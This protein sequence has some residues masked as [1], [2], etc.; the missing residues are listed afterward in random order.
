MKRILLICLCP[1][2][3]LSSCSVPFSKENRR[4]EVILEE[5]LMQFSICDGFLYQKTGDAEHPLTDAMLTRLFEGADLADLRYVAS[6]AVF[7]S[8]RYRSTEIMIIELYDISHR[9]ALQKLLEKR[10]K[11][12]ENAVVLTNG[13]YLYLICTEQ[14]EEIKKFLLSR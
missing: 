6:M 7:L 13:V 8:R 4:A 12:K 3:F 14:N 5:M 1:I 2:I 10:A 9:D 11:K